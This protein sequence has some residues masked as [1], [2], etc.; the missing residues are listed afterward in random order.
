ML[1][2]L[3]VPIV[4]LILTLG[5][6][7]FVDAAAAPRERV[8]AHD[9]APFP[10]ADPAAAGMDAAIAGVADAV[11]GW[12][13]DGSL[14]GGE[15]L[16]VKRERIIW[17]EVFGVRDLETGEPLHP[18]GVYRIRS[19]T[20]PFIG[21]AAF[22]LA[23]AGRLDL[24]APVA[25][26]LPSMDHGEAREVTVRQ[27]LH[28]TAGFEF[29]PFPRDRASYAS[30]RESVDDVAREGPTRA[31]GAFHYSD[32]GT[33]MLGAVIEEAAGIPLSE[34]LEREVFVPLG[35]GETFTRFT[36]DAPWADRMTST[37]RWDPDL[38]RHVRYWHPGEPQAMPYFRAS[39]GIYATVFDYARFLDAWRTGRDAKGYELLSP[40][41]R[42]DALRSV[43]EIPYGSHWEVVVDDAGTT[44]GFGHG[45]SDG[46]MALCFPEEELLLLFFTQ[47]RGCDCRDQVAMLAGLTGTFGPLAEHTVWGRWRAPSSGRSPDS[48]DPA[49]P[50]TLTAD[51]RAA[52]VGTYE[53]RGETVRIEDRDG[54]LHL[55][56]GVRA[57]DEAS[58]AS[59]ADPVAAGPVDHP[60]EGRIVCIPA[61][62]VPVPEV[63]LE[64]L[65]DHRFGFARI[66]GGEV[67]ERYWPGRPLTFLLEGNEVVGYEV[68]YEPQVI[69]HARRYRWRPAPPPREGR[70]IPDELLGI[71]GRY[72][73]GTWSAEVVVA[74]D[75][76]ILDFGGTPD[77][78]LHQGDGFLL[79]PRD[80]VV[81]FS[82]DP[83]TGRM[84]LRAVDGD[85]RTYTF[86]RWE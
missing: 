43:T 59:V 10:Y 5:G 40:E 56:R 52:Y 11:A 19:M 41:T 26:T 34:V 22:R 15:L 36:P 20:K 16:V 17:H 72:E 64:P 53:V 54:V 35:L 6:M 50:V 32:A 84:R 58:D 47:S 75:R 74:D 78:L 69:E 23:E 70:A 37:H 83:E 55:R 66:V 71:A 48:P 7:P 51:D 86:T 76:V 14:V 49:S 85:R 30:L 3:E 62:A 1:A 12:V 65:G 21:T 46:T 29:S 28:H 39:G 18:G 67:V 24:D 57:R 42:A 13:D 77:T 27:L 73:S 2:R 38:R 44:R 25:R 79:G 63:A 8:H 81:V 33:A 4:A 31:R 61:L 68:T 60:D 9:R 80:D 45:G 82:P